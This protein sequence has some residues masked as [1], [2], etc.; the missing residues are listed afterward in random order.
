VVAWLSG[1]SAFALRVLPGLL[2]TMAALWLPLL[3]R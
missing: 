3:Y 1:G 2:L